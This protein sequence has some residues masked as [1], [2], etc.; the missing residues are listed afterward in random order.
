MKQE[1]H[2]MF[3]EKMDRTNLVY[4]ELDSAN[5]LH[6]EFYEHD[7]NLCKQGLAFFKTGTPTA[8]EVLLRNKF[9]PV[10]FSEGM[11]WFKTQAQTDDDYQKDFELRDK[12]RE[13]ALQRTR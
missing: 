1:I 8:E 13:F 5:P 10:D 4:S 7:V 6:N 9:N 11:Q 2:K 12:V 3:E